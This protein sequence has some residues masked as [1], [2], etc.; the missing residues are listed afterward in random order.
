[1]CCQDWVDLQLETVGEP[2]TL[3]VLASVFP[4]RACAESEF[5]RGVKIRDDAYFQR[6]F[7]FQLLLMRLRQYDYAD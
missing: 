4:A 2:F 1:R 7:S 5:A 3:I 6:F